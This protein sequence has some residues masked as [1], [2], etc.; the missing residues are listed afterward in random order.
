M[1]LIQMIVQMSGEAGRDEW[2]F[3]T[4]DLAKGT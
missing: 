4:M 3:L 2:R 1:V